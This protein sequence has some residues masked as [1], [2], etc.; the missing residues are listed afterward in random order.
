MSASRFAEG[1][2]HAGPLWRWAGGPNGG[3]WYFVT[4]DGAAAEALSGT[5]IMRKLE[6]SGRGFGSMKVR[7]RIGA[8]VFETSVFP[9]KSN[10]GWL[11]PVKAS[12]RK[13][14][15]VD[16]GVAVDVFLEF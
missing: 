16:E 5:A 14:E 11:L 4:I 12:V 1:V 3:A 2:E 9:S 13:A 15:A 7:A 6:G 10:G 8:T